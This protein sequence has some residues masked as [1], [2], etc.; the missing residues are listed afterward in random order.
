MNFEP[1]SVESPRFVPY[2]AN[3]PGEL[4]PKAAFGNECREASEP[5]VSD[6][7]LKQIPIEI[8]PT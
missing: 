8:A 4:K 5:G 7:L 3:S 2:Q 6:G 1:V